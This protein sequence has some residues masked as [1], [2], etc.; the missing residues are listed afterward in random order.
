MCIKFEDK[1]PPSPPENVTYF[2]KDKKLTII[3]HQPEDEDLAGFLIYKNG[4]PYT[5]FIIKSYYFIDKDF[6]KGD[7]YQIFSVDKGGNKSP[8]V[9]LKIE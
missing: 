4:K 3:W 1:F 9:Y 8:P 2:I 5:N 7:T 6:K